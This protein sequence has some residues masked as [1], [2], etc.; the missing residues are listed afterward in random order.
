MVGGGGVRNREGRGD[1]KSGR[2]RERLIYLDV[3]LLK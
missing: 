3:C 2:K 1:G